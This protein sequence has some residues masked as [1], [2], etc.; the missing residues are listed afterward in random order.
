M[1]AS[2]IVALTTRAML[3]RKGYDFDFERENAMKDYVRTREEIRARTG[4]R[5]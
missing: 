4:G 3:N 2:R 1:K 5:P